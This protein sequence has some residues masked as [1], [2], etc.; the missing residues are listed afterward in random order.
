MILTAMDSENC[1]DNGMSLL[2]ILNMEPFLRVLQIYSK[3]VLYQTFIV[4]Y[5]KH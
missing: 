3:F 5:T 4:L 1:Q 2:E